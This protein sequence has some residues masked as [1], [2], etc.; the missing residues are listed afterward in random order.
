MAGGLCPST[1]DSKKEGTKKGLLEQ[2]TKKRCTADK[3]V[4]RPDPRPPNIEKELHMNW[5]LSVTVHSNL[6]SDIILYV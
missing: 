2:P 1:V 6:T 3:E 5:S 4:K